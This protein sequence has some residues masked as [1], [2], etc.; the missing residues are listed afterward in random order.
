M[1]ILKNMKI[2]NKLL[3]PVILQIVLLVLTVVLYFFISAVI[4]KQEAENEV[5]KVTTSRLRGML[6]SID[7]Y[8]NGE[9]SYEAISGEFQDVL[10]EVKKNEIFE[11]KSRMTAFAGLDKQFKDVDTMTK[12]NVDIEEQVMELTSFS[13][14]QSDTY[15]KEISRKLANRALR[16]SVSDLERLVIA[17]AAVNTGANFNIKVLFLQ[18]KE[19]LDTGEQ[20]LA[21]L[22]ESIKNTAIDEK[23]LAGTP[24]AELPTK[25][26]EANLKIKELVTRFVEN[27]KRLLQIRDG[28]HDVYGG[29]LKYIDDWEM[30]RNADTFD[31]IRKGFLTLFAVIGLI[32]LL[33]IVLSLTLTKFISA[34]VNELTE[35]AYDLAVGEVDMTKRL[36]VESTD[37][38]GELGGWFNQFL[39]RLHQIIIKVRDSSMDIHNATEEIS[40]ASE[41]LAHRTNEQAA[42]ITQTSTTLEE[43]TSSV[44]NNTE[45]SAEAD[46]MLTSFNEEIQEKKVLIENVT[47][48]MTEIFDSSKQIDNIIK[49]IN[50]ISFQTNLLALNAAVEAARAGE[51]GRGF[52]VV[53]AEVRN[54]AQ[55]TAE[56][57]KSI[58][59][60]VQQNVETTQKGME[61][62]RD[63]SQFFAEV[64]E[65]MGE[66]VVKI[67]NITNA[68]REQSTGI[69]QI[70]KAIGHMDEVSTHN[71]GLVEELSATSKTVKSN[72][73][74][75]EDLVKQFKLAD[76][77]DVKGSDY[78]A[79]VTKQKKKAKKKVENEK[80]MEPETKPDINKKDT[81]PTE[82]DFFGTDGEEGF[83]E[84]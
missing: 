39:E 25:A 82:D 84:F 58:Q 49:V 44:R 33:I 29:L 54:L 13:I 63:T 4:K 81:T 52:A 28:I 24:F 10:T 68:S 42:A 70:N 43:F 65:M 67:S 69:E 53:A 37:D 27:S 83:E 6:V 5:V 12:E 61:L 75:L 57:S 31:S 8:L 15:L 45:N 34:P 32:A 56:S 3:V 50:D 74:D 71:A 1:N 11:E 73:M 40:T 78:Y 20:L 59:N 22:D 64:V 17:G 76:S 72:A 19:K 18:V 16:G 60:I 26:Q 23:R 38:F 48:T 36:L 2:R 30:K 47:T 46:M 77:S 7:S 55:K 14:R 51:A 80:P 9:N 35:R 21:F 66:T 79:E 41:D 62:V